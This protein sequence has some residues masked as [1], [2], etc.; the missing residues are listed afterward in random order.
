MSLEKEKLFKFLAE[1]QLEQYFQ[2]V[3]EK[4][5]VTRISH[6]DHV[7]D[8]DLFDIG[9]VKPEQRRLFE[10]LK[11]VKKKNFFGKFKVMDP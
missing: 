9:M 5:H 2:V 7:E 8:S 1:V 11:K 4:L 6:F 10:H 3:V